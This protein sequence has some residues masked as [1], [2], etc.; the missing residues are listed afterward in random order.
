MK[1]APRLA[2]ALILLAGC[3]RP[4][5]ETKASPEAKAS[6]DTAVLD[7]AAPLVV[8]VH[9]WGGVPG[10]LDHT[11][12][13]VDDGSV[14]LYGYDAMWCIRAK[15][16]WPSG[17]RRLDTRSALD[18]RTFEEIRAL[19]SD[20]DV[21]RYPSAPPPARAPESDG[22]AAEV[23]LSTHGPILIDGV[24][25]L[26]GKMARL[27]DLDREIADRLGVAAACHD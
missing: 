19:A 20:P 27:L 3:S 8:R 11:L 5:P 26:K 2:C 18:A 10:S 13:V 1:T 7:A 23:S 6:P 21:A 17:P 15:K 24:R 12:E 4:T 16:K 9:R 25:E 14:H 22:V